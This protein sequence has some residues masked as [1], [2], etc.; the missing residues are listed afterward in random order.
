MTWL[1]FVGAL[2]PGIVGAAITL[3]PV[4]AVWSMSLRGLKP[5]IQMQGEALV[6]LGKHHAECE[7]KVAVL[8]GEVEAMK[9]Q[10]AQHSQ[11]AAFQM[12][13][14]GTE[15]VMHDPTTNSRTP[16]RKGDEA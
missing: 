15:P 2:V 11:S 5:V 6:T 13:R 1:E 9:R 14:P 16:I 12:G 3:L 7:K 8:S 4:A 10:L